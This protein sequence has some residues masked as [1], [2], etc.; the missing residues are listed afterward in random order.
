MTLATSSPEEIEEMLN[1]M[2]RNRDTIEADIATIVY[3]MNGGL[4]FNAAYLLTLEQ[5]ER[6]VKVIVRDLESK[7][8]NKQKQL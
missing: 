2:G 4:D 6:L 8:P 7:N 1:T 5:R 3:Y